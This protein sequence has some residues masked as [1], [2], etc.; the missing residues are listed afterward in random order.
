MSVGWIV[1][2]LVGWALGLGFTLLLLRMA[3]DQD[4]AARHQEKLLFPYS[5]VTITRIGNYARVPVTR[6]PQELSG[7]S[8][9]RVLT[10]T[11]SSARPPG[12]RT[13]LSVDFQPRTSIKWA[14]AKRSR[15]WARQRQ[16]SRLAERIRSH[17]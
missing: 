9:S 10:K 13:K 3:S 4:R 2:V 17:G 6:E 7:P 5:D 8:S 16:R 1:L 14:L 15:Y 12:N 11:G